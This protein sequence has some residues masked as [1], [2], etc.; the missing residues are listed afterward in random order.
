MASKMSENPGDA[1]A[2]VFKL[3]YSSADTPVYAVVPSYHVTPENEATVSAPYG[4]ILGIRSGPCG[5]T[6]NMVRIMCW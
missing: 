6:Q 5:I 4:A 2:L 3:C 1:K